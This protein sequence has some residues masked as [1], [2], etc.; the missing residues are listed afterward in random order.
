MSIVY[1]IQLLGPSHIEIAGHPL[2]L[3]TLRSRKALALFGYLTCRQEPVLRTHLAHL[4]WPVRPESR[5]RRNLSRELSQLAT[6]LPLC[7]EGDYHTIWFKP[8]TDYWLDIWT[9]E[10][11]LKDARLN[12]ANQEELAELWEPGTELIVEPTE[13]DPARIAEAVALYRGNFMADY[14]LECCPGFK[15]W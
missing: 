12:E 4:F 3:A 15:V 13:A 9:F 7:L 1:R 11:L 8:G 6:Y 2:P 10:A 5:G 14:H